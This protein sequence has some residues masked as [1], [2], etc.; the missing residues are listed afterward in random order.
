MAFFDK[1]GETLSNTG[2]DVAK[3]A[4]ELAEVASLNSQVSAQEES[5]NKVFL[6]IGKMVYEKKEEWTSPE[7]AEKFGTV[8]AAYAEIARLKKE[9]MT[10]KGVKQCPK[11]GAEVQ[12]DSAFCPSC[13]TA[14]PKEEPQAAEP[15]QE[16]APA[17]EEAAA[18]QAAEA[19]QDAAPE[20]EKTT[21]T[22]G[23]NA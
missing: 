21:D 23:I 7:M 8:D 4:K 22:D 5:I 18:P 19:V 1:L 12:N 14:I 20:A 15:V 10:V 11:C 16:E 2:K 13:G 6:E 3:K 17:E 9:I